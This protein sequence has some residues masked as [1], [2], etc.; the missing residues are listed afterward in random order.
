MDQY[1]RWLKDMNWTVS[2]L[3]LMLTDR[4]STTLSPDIENLTATLKN[5][6]ASQDLS[7]AGEAA[8]ITAAAP[9]IAAATQLCSAETAAA[10]LQWLNQ[11]KP[12]SLTVSGLLTLVDKEPGTRTDDETAKM[13]SFC[14]VMGQLALIARNASLSASEL[15]WVVA[16]P[17]V[18]TEKA[19]ALGHDITTLHDLTQLHALLAR[20]GTYASE[21]LTSLSGKAGAEK[22]NL[23]VKTV[24][25][26]LTLDEQALTQALAQTSAYA[27]FYSWIHL[28]NALQWLNVAG[29]FGITPANVA[30]LVKLTYSSPYAS[31]VAASHALQAGLN[32]QQTAQLQAGLD[33]ALSTAVSAYVI[34]NIAPSWVDSRDRLYSWLL[35]DNQVSAQVKT[36]RLR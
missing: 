4:F 19:T 1:A 3:C 26:A 35:I 15:S 14:Q 6:L 20:C 17:T 7:G 28:R 25:T 2:D 9:F 23:A 10:V 8:L 29:T 5:G 18:I 32:T 24:A 13:V 36:T 31:W 30:A 34:K 12:Q 11:L 16:H 27:Y 33:E 21:I 22:N